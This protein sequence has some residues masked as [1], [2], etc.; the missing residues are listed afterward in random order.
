MGSAIGRNG[1]SGPG[2]LELTSC[3]YFSF[4]AEEAKYFRIPAGLPHIYGKEVPS[5]A[6]TFQDSSEGN[7]I[8]NKAKIGKVVIQHA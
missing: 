8:H 3:K 7:W 1:Q 5:I 4:N 6:A 2:I